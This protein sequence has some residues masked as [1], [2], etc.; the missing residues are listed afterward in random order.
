MTVYDRGMRSTPHALSL[1]LLYRIIVNRSYP[2]VSKRRGKLGIRSSHLI[3]N[4]NGDLAN[5]VTPMSIDRYDIGE[6]VRY[7]HGVSAVGFE[8]EYFDGRVMVEHDQ[9]YSESSDDVPL[10]GQVISNNDKN[11]NERIFYKEDIR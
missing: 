6:I 10:V 2:L 9:L 4:S 7:N 1:G 5:V 3:L 11:I 8:V